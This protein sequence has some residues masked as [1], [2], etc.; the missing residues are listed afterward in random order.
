MKIGVCGVGM[1]GG[2]VKFG[3]ERLGHEVIGYDPFKAGFNGNLNRLEK[4]DLIFVC[5]PTP[6]KPDGSCDTSIVEQSVRILSCNYNGVIVIKSTVTPG[7]T[8][9]LA[10]ELFA[11]KI[12]F[13]P[14]FLRERT[15]IADFCDYHDVCIIGAYRDHDFDL[16][17][18]AHGHYPKR[19]VRLTPTEAELAKYFSNVY[20]ALRITF[21][22]QFYEVCQEI[23][24][25]YTA[26]KDAVSLR[27]S[28]GNHYLDCNANLREYGGNCLPKDVKAFMRFAEAVGA[29]ELLWRDIETL[30]EW[31]GEDDAKVA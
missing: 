6:G 30:N 31:V 5:V 18:R 22:N 29:R 2:T 10:K 20:N 11:N 1:V 9:R 17:K 24:A 25:D 8:E 26:I 7:T 27:T 13:C 28:V 23:G 12:A 15:A 19:F 4:T 16:I 3:L 21:A 14:E